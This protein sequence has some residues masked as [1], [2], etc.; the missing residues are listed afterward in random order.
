M[1]VWIVELSSGKDFA[2]CLPYFDMTGLVDF[3]Y[4][5][6]EVF[7]NGLIY[8]LTYLFVSSTGKLRDKASLYKGF[9]ICSYAEQP[10]STR[11][12]PEVR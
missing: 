6:F 12:F 3:D 8:C 1:N 5:R 10:L 11:F 2:H 9:D 7:L 4:F